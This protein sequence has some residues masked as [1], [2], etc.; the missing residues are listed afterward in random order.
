MSDAWR[1]RLRIPLHRLRSIK[2]TPV[3]KEVWPG[4][5]K[6]EPKQLRGMSL[7]RKLAQK[8]YIFKTH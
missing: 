6:K 2:T 8:Y 1:C 7:V 4:E 5:V 3:F